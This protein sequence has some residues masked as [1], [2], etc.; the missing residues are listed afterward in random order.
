MKK[1]INGLFI[2]MLAMFVLPSCK[3]SFEDLYQNP[4]KPV[5]APASLLLN[6]VLNDMYDAPASLYERWS[7]YFVINYDYYGNNR[8]D[9]GEGTNYYSTLK[10]VVKMEEEAT[11]AGL[12]QVN[13][14]SALGK[15]F[16]AYFFTKMSL[17]VGDIPMTEALKGLDNFSP[18]YDPQKKVFEQAFLWLDSANSELG[19][20][21]A[22]N[23]NNL[24]GDI[25][26][27]NNLPKWQKAVNTFRL[28]LLINLSKKIA[29]PDLN[30]KQQFSNIVSNESQYPIMDGISDNL[31]YQYVFPTNLYPNNPG[32][33]GFDALRYN[34]S[35]TY[36]VLLTQLND[37]RVFVT[38]EPATALVKGGKNPTAFD[39]FIG[40]SPG[41]DLGDMYLKTNNGQYS[42]L[43]RK[44]YYDTYTGEPSI[45]I[46]YPEMLFN[47]AEAINR[48]WITS[49]PLGGAEE[50]YK[51]GIEASMAFYNIPLSG[52]MT[53]YFLHPGASLGVYDT[54]TVNVDFSSYYNQASVKYSG[55]NPAGLTQLL[56]QKYLALFRHSGLEGYYQFRRTGVPSF[57]T[58]PGTGNSDRIA[59]R[60]QYSGTEKTANAKNYQD[61]LQSQYGGN[62]DINGVMW[63]LQ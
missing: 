55:D 5:S 24:Q 42:L 40:A 63:L 46:G 61:A 17:Q 8:Y 58:G 41:E 48:G 39:A 43:N 32:N 7:Q 45:Q 49:G 47:I 25:Y 15:F 9:F 12:P 22:S 1:I 51:A 62:D 37:P 14:Y 34:S 20:L 35:A 56:D 50:Y 52:A 31:Q 3:K 21:A 59:V 19:S 36:V 57:T 4:N 27:S 18:V 33:F 54:Y 10:N 30:I 23:D 16:R 2:A 60:F 38:S 13:A 53:V 28:R 29:D 26:F 44:R 6:G 11:K